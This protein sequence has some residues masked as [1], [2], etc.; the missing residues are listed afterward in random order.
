MEKSLKPGGDFAN[1]LKPHEIAEAALFLINA[2]TENLDL[3]T[4]KE[5]WHTKENIT[6]VTTPDNKIGLNG[7]LIE[8]YH[9]SET[10]HNMSYIQ[11]I[12]FDKLIPF[13]K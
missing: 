10:F 4:I 2:N 6:M 8:L 9:K 13:S 7:N 11:R 12:G 1:W 5:I 3:K